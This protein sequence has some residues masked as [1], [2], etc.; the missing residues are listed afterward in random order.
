MAGAAQPAPGGLSHGQL[1]L[2]KVDLSINHLIEG[3]DNQFNVPRQ[4]G[5]PMLQAQTILF[6]RLA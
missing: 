5:K 3:L 2:T 1:V 6:G 4:D